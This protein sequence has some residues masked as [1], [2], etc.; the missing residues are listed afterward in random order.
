MP[1]TGKDEMLLRGEGSQEATIPACVCVRQWCRS[2][3]AVAY[4]TG[5]SFG[6]TPGAWYAAF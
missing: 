2:C 3:G 6:A 4:A 1:C 5:G